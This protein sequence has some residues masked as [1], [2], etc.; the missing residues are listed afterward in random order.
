ME[1][2]EAELVIRDQEGILYL[3]LP[4]LKPFIFSLFL[5]AEAP[6]VPPDVCRKQTA[7]KISI[8]H[9]TG[10]G[11]PPFFQRDKLRP[12]QLH[13]TFRKEM[14]LHFLINRYSLCPEPNT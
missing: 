5:R 10:M 2:V 9:S 3:N 8:A 13:F 11:L 6:A 12:F 7:V 1:S 4:F 14:T